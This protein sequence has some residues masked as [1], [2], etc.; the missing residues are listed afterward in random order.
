MSA[1]L[2]NVAALGYLL[3]VP[4]LILI[5]YFSRKS[6]RVEVS[7]IIPW[8][9]LKN[10]IV[11]S[12][13]FRADLLFYLQLLLLLILVLCA[14]RP[15]WGR[16]GREEEGRHVVMVMDRSASMQTMEGRSSRW[17]IARGRALRLVRRLGGGDR[18]T[19]IAAGAAPAVL[20]AGEGN[21]IRLPSPAARTAGAA[22]AA[23]S[24]TLSPPPSRRTSR[25]ARPR[26]ISHLLLRP[27]IVCMLADR[28][29][30]ITT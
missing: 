20:A 16:S 2:A 6:R 24:V 25:R 29:I 30:T 19:L 4:A 5:Y 15:Y 3:T 7:S 11:R 22:P 1:G 23:M 9:L 17:E 26:A 27:S 12:S 18:V 8:R 13:L 28:S 10:S 21:L 14:C